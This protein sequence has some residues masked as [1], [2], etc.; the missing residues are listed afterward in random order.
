MLTDVPAVAEELVD[1]ALAVGH[2]HDASVTEVDLGDVLDD[3]EPP[4]AFLVGDCLVAMADL[5]F[6][7]SVVAVEAL[8]LDEALIEQSE[9]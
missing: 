3:I 5:G 9:W 2:M 4:T 7:P 6:F 8:A 1:V